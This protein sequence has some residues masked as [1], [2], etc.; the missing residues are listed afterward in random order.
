M[1]GAQTQ[2]ESFLQCRI[3]RDM[4]VGKRAG[5]AELTGVAT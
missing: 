4:A 5:A 3:W 1:C 2:A